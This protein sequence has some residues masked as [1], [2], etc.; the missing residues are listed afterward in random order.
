[1]DSNGNFKKSIKD[2]WDKVPKFRDSMGSVATLHI[3]C[4]KTLITSAL[5]DENFMVGTMTKA[6]QYF[7]K[8]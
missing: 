7:Y 6:N 8:L 3:P 1:M 5:G 2:L 4:S